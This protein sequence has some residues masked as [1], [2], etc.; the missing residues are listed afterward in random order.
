[1]L[2]KITGHN[3]RLLL[4]L[5]LSTAQH[6]TVFIMWLRGHIKCEVKGETLQTWGG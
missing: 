5:P 3:E 1:M 2:P 6:L 4:S